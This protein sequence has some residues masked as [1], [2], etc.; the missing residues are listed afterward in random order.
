MFGKYHDQVFHD[1]TNSGIN[2]VVQ[3]YRFRHNNGKHSY[4]DFNIGDTILI[5]IDSES[6]FSKKYV[7][8][9]DNDCWSLEHG[10]SVIRMTDEYIKKNKDYIKRILE[11]NE[12][13]DLLD[14]YKVHYFSSFCSMYDK[15]KILTCRS[16]IH[17]SIPTFTCQLCNSECTEYLPAHKCCGKCFFVDKIEVSSSEWYQ[18]ISSLRAPN[19]SE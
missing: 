11:I 13:P 1:L 5:A 12:L 18:N 8:A 16:N 3:K 10:F 6:N 19:L 17:N 15:L 7:H 9:S 2:D 14:N 4:Y